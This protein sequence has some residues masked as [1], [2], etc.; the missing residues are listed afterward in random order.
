[1]TDNG[2]R[3]RLRFDDL[4]HHTTQDG[5]CR[6]EVRLE[7]CG[8]SYNGTEEGLETQQGRLRAATL[9]A[10][11]AVAAAAGDQLG[12]ELAGVKAVRV[13]DGWVVVAAVRGTGQGKPLRLLGSAACGDEEAIERSAA[14][15]VLDATNR[16]VERLTPC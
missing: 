6:V 7:W 12:L 14:L 2:R 8:V 1:M 3:Q 5:R 13:F 15:A 9:A 4:H 10:L 16:V 11:R